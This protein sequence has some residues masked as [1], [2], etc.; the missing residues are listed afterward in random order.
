M[1]LSLPPSNCLK[2]IKPTT[3][4]TEFDYVANHVVE[5]LS[6]CDPKL[7]MRWCESIMASEKIK[8]R[9]FSDDFIQVL[10]QLKSSAQNFKL[11]SVYW[12]WSNH[13]ILL[14]L[15]QFS[16]LALDMLLEFNSRLNNHLP[17]SLYPI[18]SFDPSMI[19]YD[20]SQHTILAIKCSKELQQSLQLVFDME[21]LL[22]EKFNITKHCFH[23]LAVQ[24]KPTR[25][26]WMIPKS[27]ADIVDK[28]LDYIQ[29]SFLSFD[30]G[31]Q[32]PFEGNVVDLF[33]YPNTLYVFGMFHTTKMVSQ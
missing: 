4:E 8:T 12:S 16:K 13:S 31:H 2:Y 26:Y 23:L 33:I 5:L 22:I 19:P 17:L 25:L 1:S 27:I 7:L 30:F 14:M 3:V 24:Y 15:A 10:K 20:D 18:S 6:C 28:N 21:S 9:L 32:V 11:L 29:G